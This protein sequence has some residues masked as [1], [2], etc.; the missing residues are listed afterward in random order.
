MLTLLVIP[1]VSMSADPNAIFVEG[2]KAYAEKDQLRA[3][4]LF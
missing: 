2:K 1:S 4:E 3:A